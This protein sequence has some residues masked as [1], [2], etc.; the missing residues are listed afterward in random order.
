M[1]SELQETEQQASVLVQLGEQYS[2]APNKLLKTLKETAFKGATD[3]QMIA[4]CIVAS[5]YR[6]NPFTKEIY[7][8]PAKG[9]GIVPVIGVDGWYG[10]VNSQPH[11]DG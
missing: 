9:G 10:L 6:L 11:Y 3:S 1:K 8:Y 2:V 4:L 7:A 5:E